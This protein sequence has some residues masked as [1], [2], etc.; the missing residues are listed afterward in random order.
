VVAELPL[1]R[2]SVEGGEAYDKIPVEMAGSEE[3]DGQEE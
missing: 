2:D 1:L 3:L